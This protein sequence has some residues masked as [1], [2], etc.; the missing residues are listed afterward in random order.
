MHNIDPQKDKTDNP[1]NFRPTLESVLLKV[2]TSCLRNKIF[3]FLSQHN[4][5]AHDIQK[6][7][8][9]NVS[10][11]IENAAHMAHIIN[12]ARIQNKGNL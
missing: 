11:T 8:T 10:G 7:F 6:G 12:I 3:T 5:I 4:Y 9:P 2:F 1:A